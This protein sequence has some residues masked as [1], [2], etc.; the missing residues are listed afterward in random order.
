MVCCTTLWWDCAGK[1]RGWKT[2][3]IIYCCQQ[4]RGRGRTVQ[5]SNISSGA[6]CVADLDSRALTLTKEASGNS[7]GV[8]VCVCFCVSLC[9]CA[10]LFCC[11]YCHWFLRPYAE[12]RGGAESYLT[13]VERPQRVRRCCRESV[14]K[15]SAPAPP[16]GTS[17]W[18]WWSRWCSRRAWRLSRRRRRCYLEERVGQFSSVGP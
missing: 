14:W 11:F 3:A 1:G 10:C 18:S 13:P 15:Q 2:A 8:C 4:Q 12:E 9:L 5:L 16:E 7:R 6:T 17:L